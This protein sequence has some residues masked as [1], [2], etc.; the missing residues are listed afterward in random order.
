[1]NKSIIAMAAGMGSRFGGL[2]QA[3]KFGPENKTML[4]FALEDALAAGF[5]KAVFVIRRDIEK[6]FREC[7]SGKYE[8]KTD[9]RYVFQDESGQ[10]LPEGRTKPW[11]TGHAVLACIDEISEPFLAINA[12]DYYGSGV[13]GQAAEFLQSPNPRRYALAG[14]RLKNTLSKNGGVSRGIC[15]V[16]ENLKLISIRE[17]TGLSGKTSADGKSFVEDAEGAK[18]SGDEFT[19]LN[20]WAFPKEFMER[21]GIGFDKF[22]SKNSRDAKAEYYLPKAVDD[23]VAEKFAEVAVMPTPERWQGVTYKEDIETVRE[24][25]ESEGRI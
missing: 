22:L 25:L 21:L 19:S 12:D 6:I 23:A 2:K 10:P 5:T 9:V 13:Y 16:D 18:F 14:Y 4:D 11:G 3:A 17:H 20:F 7:L 15:A 8:N 1:M 24:F